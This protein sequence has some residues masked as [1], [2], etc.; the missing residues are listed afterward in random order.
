MRVQRQVTLDAQFGRDIE[1]LR[2]EFRP[3][4]LG[5]RDDVFVPVR[6]VAPEGDAITLFVQ[7]SDIYVLGW[8]NAHGEFYLS[9]HPASP[10]P[11]SVWFSSHYRTKDLNAFAGPPITKYGIATAVTRLG[12]AETVA[13]ANKLRADVAL[14]AFTVPEALRQ[15]VVAGLMESLF[16]N[17]RASGS[18]GRNL[19]RHYAN[20][21]SDNY[22][23]GDPYVELPV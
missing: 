6:V 14:M 10:S 4:A 12:R 19:I 15:D 17:R 5:T 3:S 9:D 22:E 7:A 23:A 8:Q 21:Y 16:A 18:I 20:N 2:Y 13:A 1:W 11:N